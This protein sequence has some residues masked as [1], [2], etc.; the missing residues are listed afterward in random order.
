MSLL[1]AAAGGGGQVTSLKQG[2]GYVL[3]A[4]AL[5][6]VVF[7]AVKLFAAWM[8]FDNNQPE[9]FKGKLIAGIGLLLSTGISGAAAA[10]ILGAD[11]QITADFSIW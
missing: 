4:I 6:S 11:A 8:A 3:A 10:A 7:A 2:L 1:G 9:N 5:L